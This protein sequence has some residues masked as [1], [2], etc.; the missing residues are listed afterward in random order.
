MKLNV[1]ADL[2]LENLAIAVREYSIDCSV[3]DF[4]SMAFEIIEFLIYRANILDNRK[5][6]MKK[7]KKHIQKIDGKNV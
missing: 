3:K 4:N 1:Q 2:T 5:L 6:L 7:V